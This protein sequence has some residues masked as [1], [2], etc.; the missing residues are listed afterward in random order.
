MLRCNINLSSLSQ[1]D[2]ICGECKAC[3][4]ISKLNY[5]FERDLATSKDLVAA[6]STIIKNITKYK[7]IGPEI[8]KNPDIRVIDIE[9]GN[10]II[11]RVEAKYLGG[12]AFMKTKEILTDKLEPKETLVVDEPKLLS[13]FDCKENDF[14]VYNR[15]IPIYIVWKFDRPCT[16]YGGITVFQEISILKRIYETHGRNRA[17]ERKTGTGDITNGQKMGIT[18]KYHFSLRECRSIEELI[19]EILRIK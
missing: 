19:S 9:N 12:K 15:N 1:E 10:K 13:Y 8:V 4:P 14:K 16:D 18:T 2:F 17:F 7:C 11:C 3:E 5:P 6:L